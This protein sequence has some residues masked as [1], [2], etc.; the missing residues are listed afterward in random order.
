MTKSYDIDNPFDELNLTAAWWN[1][2]PTDAGDG[3]GYTGMALFVKRFNGPH[4]EQTEFQGPFLP[5]LVDKGIAWASETT[6]APQE[7]SKTKRVIPRT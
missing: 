7:T 6:K 2:R 3:K 5:D 4:I 1:L